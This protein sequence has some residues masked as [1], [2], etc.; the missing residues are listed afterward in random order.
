M[1]YTYVG[2]IMKKTKEGNGS[3]S[4]VHLCRDKKDDGNE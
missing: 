1:M 3:G 4:Y 2:M